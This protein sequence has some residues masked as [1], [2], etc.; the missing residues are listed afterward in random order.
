MKPFTLL[1]LL[2]S[3][4]SYSQDIPTAIS[5]YASS[6]ADTGDFSGCIL[7][8]KSDGLLY[9]QCFGLANE[10][11]ALENTPAT[12]FMIGS[13]SKQFT[14]TAI[15]L[16]EEQGL[17][18]TGD[19]LSRFFDISDSASGIT[20]EQ[21]MTH[22]SGV[23]DIFN[24]PNFNNLSAEKINL[25][26]LT[27][28]LLQ[29]PLDFD[30]GT[31]Y[32]YSNGGYALLAQIIEQ[33]SGVTF[34]D[35]IS[36]NICIPLQLK[37]TGHNMSSD[38]I[39]NLAVGYDPVGYESKRITEFLDPELLKGSG[40]LYST[41]EDL[42]KWIT[43]IKTKSLLSN[44][45]F[46]KFLNDKGNN[47]GFGISVYTSFDKNVFGH[48]G[49]INGYIADYLHYIE[50]DISVIILGN[51]QTGVSDFFRR[52][53]AAIIYNKAYK[54]RAKNTP[55][56]ERSS[57]PPK[58]LEG[59]YAFGPNFNVY[60]EIK[61]GSIH[62]RANEGGYSELVPL[63]DNRYFSRT[64]YSYITFVRNEELKIEKMLWT[65]N[66]GNT[67]EGIKNKALKN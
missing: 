55:P 53:I 40:S 60:V 35:Y 65:N 7:V 37:H 43:S 1:L 24:V 15:L 66:D 13:V 39:K 48:D 25:K 41:T 62:A 22:T 23:P 58:E 11:E 33:V 63:A 44:A 49:R 4:L 19:T 59:V 32:Q 18:H 27:D 57:I 36:K 3:L 5:S 9:Q 45:S 20:L 6:Y 28:R 54:S 61:D 14:S 42:N 38:S 12:R 30:P 51:I 64:L 17:L 31:Q 16:L 47:Y 2:L 46:E 56:L 50:D 21:L 8:T 10:E 67:F 52:D 26:G 34:G 29:M